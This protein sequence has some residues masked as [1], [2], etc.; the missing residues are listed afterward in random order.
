[1]PESS[2]RERKKEC[3]KKAKGKGKTKTKD[4]S[5]LWSFVLNRLSA[6]RSW[7]DL[8]AFYRPMLY[9]GRKAMPIGCQVLIKILLLIFCL[10]I[11]WNVIVY[12]KHVKFMDI[13]GKD[14]VSLDWMDILAIE[15]NAKSNFPSKSK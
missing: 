13:N 2:K 15:Q 14:R 10:P 4:Q 8:R 12:P 5:G 3:R 11:R 1:M 6:S 9:I 7:A